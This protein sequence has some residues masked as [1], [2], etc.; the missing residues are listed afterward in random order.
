MPSELSQKK[1]TCT[2][3]NREMG[4][5]SRRSHLQGKSHLAKVAASESTAAN[6]LGS[7]ND[8]MNDTGAGALPGVWTCTTCNC[9]MPISCRETH[10]KG[11]PHRKKA[12]APS[13][14]SNEELRSK[15]EYWTCT[16]C[17]CNV[18][19]GS[20]EMHL[21]GKPH[22][23][24]TARA[25]NGT[26][27]SSSVRDPYPVVIDRQPPTTQ[28]SQASQNWTC[29]PCG[30]QMNVQNREQHVQGKQHKAVVE[31]NG[32]ENITN[33]GAGFWICTICSV[34][35]NAKHR[36]R[37]LRGD[38]HATWLARRRSNDYD[39]D[40]DDDDDSHIRGSGITGGSGGPGRRRGPARGGS[41]GGGPG[42]G[43]GGGG[44]GGGGGGGGPSG[45][46]GGRGRGG[47]RGQY[48]YDWSDG[49]DLLGP[50]SGE[51]MLDYIAELGY[52]R[53]PSGGGWSSGEDYY[54]ERPWKKKGNGYH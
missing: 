36:G 20:R 10:V 25:R 30:R 19:L 39:D 28:P 33:V 49:G 13:S 29:E 34:K 52:G 16:I 21:K 23:K 18:P 40:D 9:Q 44:P 2:V 3:C 47:G 53:I 24:K 14:A 48:R 22:L 1:W 42:R 32:V 31:G 37:H 43:G 54:V 35:M 15:L 8:N 5:L 7:G 45:G 17:D 6:E 41:R 27:A 46:G 4:L 12:S 38:L 50:E 51:E 26:G 11:Q